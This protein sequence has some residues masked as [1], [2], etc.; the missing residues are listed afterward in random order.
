M[1]FLPFHD[2][3]LRLLNAPPPCGGGKN[4]SSLV[5]KWRGKLNE[6]LCELYIYKYVF[7]LCQVYSLGWKPG[8]REECQQCAG[9]DRRWRAGPRISSS[10]PHLMSGEISADGNSLPEGS[11]F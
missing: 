3:E 8:R 4:R 5:A 11:T 7:C 1:F 6:L 10:F 9:L 2:R